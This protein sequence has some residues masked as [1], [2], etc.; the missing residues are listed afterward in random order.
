[1]TRAR[2]PR[3][4]RANKPLVAAPASGAGG[5]RE[6]KTAH[7]SPTMEKSHVVSRPYRRQSAARRRSGGYEATGR[8][9]TRAGE[10][11]A[12]SGQVDSSLAGRR[13]VHQYQRVRGGEPAGTP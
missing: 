2:G 9:R 5:G 8:A 12:A 11:T 6:S 10:G 7:R 4:R 3:W 1:M 13:E